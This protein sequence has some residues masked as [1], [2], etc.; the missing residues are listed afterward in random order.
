MARTRGLGS[1]RLQVL[2]AAL[3]FL[4]FAA[5]VE[6]RSLRLPTFL[7]SN[8]VLQRA[9]ARA[10]VWGWAAPGALVTVELTKEPAEEGGVESDDA[11]AIIANDADR[12]RPPRAVLATARTSAAAGTG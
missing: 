4:A 12:I 6:P 10:A 2:V 9:P 8:A 5:P 7:G 11:S 1:P 3:S